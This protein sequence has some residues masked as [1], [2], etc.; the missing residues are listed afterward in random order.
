MWWHLKFWFSHE[1][2]ISSMQRSTV[3]LLRI[4]IIHQMIALIALNR[5]RA[6]TH[7]KKNE[8]DTWTASEAHFEHCYTITTYSMGHS[9]S[10]FSILCPWTVEAYLENTHVNS[11]WQMQLNK[12]QKVF[13]NLTTISSNCCQLTQIICGLMKSM[14]WGFRFRLKSSTLSTKNDKIHLFELRVNRNLFLIS[15]SM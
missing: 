8:R 5:L 7:V 6:H 9:S 14:A 4:Q 1:N 13:F 12:Q 2:Q 11:I 3:H 10:S 15:V